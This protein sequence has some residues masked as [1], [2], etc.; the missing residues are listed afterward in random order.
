MI[1]GAGFIP[2]EGSKDHAFRS[3]TIQRN[4]HKCQAAEQDATKGGEMDGDTTR[5][6]DPN[7]KI[8][9]RDPT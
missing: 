1:A 8:L 3:C 5:E 2:V 7:P 9:S 4:P 6:Y